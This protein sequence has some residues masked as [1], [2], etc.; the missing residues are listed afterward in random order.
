MGVKMTDFW[1]GSQED[2]RAAGSKAEAQTA[3][4][5]LRMLTPEYAGVVQRL[6]SLIEQPCCGFATPASTSLAVGVLNDTDS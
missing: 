3:Q 1:N 2:R 6:W 4:D 5:I